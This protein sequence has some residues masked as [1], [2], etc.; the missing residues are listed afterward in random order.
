MSDDPVAKLI[1]L[2]KPDTEISK[3]RKQK[4][5]GRP[6]ALKVVEEF[7][8]LTVWNCCEA[9]GP[10]CIITAAGSGLCAHP[11]KAALQSDDM[12]IPAVLA[13]YKRAKAELEKQ[14]I[15]KKMKE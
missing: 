12:K 2:A 8:G 1:E 14:Q 5:R 10:R 3:R 13:K 7:S 11:A 9:C 4:K 15:E 6:A